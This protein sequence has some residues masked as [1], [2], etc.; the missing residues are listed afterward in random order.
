MRVDSSRR[1]SQGEPFSEMVCCLITKEDEAI[2]LRVCLLLAIDV[3]VLCPSLAAENQTSGQKD[4]PFCINSTMANRVSSR[5]HS[6]IRTWTT[7]G[8]SPKENALRLDPRAR[9]N[10]CEPKKTY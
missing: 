6:H 8:S 10:V 2:Q 4:L 7:G 9:Q 3:K 5:P 1:Q